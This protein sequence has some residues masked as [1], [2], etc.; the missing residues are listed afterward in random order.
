MNYDPVDAKELKCQCGQPF[1]EAARIQL[2]KELAEPRATHCPPAVSLTFF[3]FG[4][5]MEALCETE[6]QVRIF[7][8]LD[9]SPHIRS[10]ITTYLLKS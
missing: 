2:L 6:S 5:D 9:L 1:K 7:V 4:R 3:L 8:P 10:S